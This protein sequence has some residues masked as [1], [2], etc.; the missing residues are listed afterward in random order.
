LP[1]RPCRR[2]HDLQAP[3]ATP[4]SI[5]PK[6]PIRRGQAATCAIQGRLA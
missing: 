6:V 3:T 1:R 5:G 4:G 2:A